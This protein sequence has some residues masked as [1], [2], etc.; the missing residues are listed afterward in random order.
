MYE[1][2]TYLKKA[3]IV[4]VLNISLGFIAMVFI[5]DGN[6][7]L[8]ARFIIIA[9]VADG[10]DGYFARRSKTESTFG[11]NFDSLSDCI[12]FGAAPALL[13]YSSGS[14]WVIPFSIIY[15]T[16]GV[17]R[18]ARY[19]VSSPELEEGTFIGTPIPLAALLLVLIVLSDLPEILT[20]GVALLLSYLMVCNI[21]FKKIAST[22][23]PLQ[24]LVILL[25]AAIPLVYI[26]PVSRI[27]FAGFLGGIFLRKKR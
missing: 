1:M 14:L 7:D 20:A 21:H 23:F 22:R 12:S 2:Q 13:M 16:A 11:M 3:D 19:N 9:I 27:A 5:L 15:V 4:T 10:F 24:N 8:A 6:L 25:L 17:L 26:V 18:L